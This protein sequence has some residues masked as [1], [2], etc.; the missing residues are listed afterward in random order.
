[1]V[2]YVRFSLPKVGPDVENWDLCHGHLLP[3]GGLLPPA[4][5]VAG[6]DE[7][8]GGLAGEGGGGG[9][10]GVGGGGGG[11]PPRGGHTAYRKVSAMR[12]INLPQLP[13]FHQISPANTK[14]TP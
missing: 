1:M 7:G 8:A 3:D 6:A 14:I 2:F 10:G 5:G 13:N 11:V 4:G 9:G 12:P